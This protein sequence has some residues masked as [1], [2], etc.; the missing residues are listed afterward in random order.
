MASAYSVQ[1]KPKKPA[2]KTSMMQEVLDKL[3]DRE[4]EVEEL[5]RENR[6]LCS[7]ALS[8]PRS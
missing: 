8:H 2:A 6:Y 7:H 5:R 4:R 1:K 3:A